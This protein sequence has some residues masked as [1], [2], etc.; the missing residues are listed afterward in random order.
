MKSKVYFTDR[1][2]RSD[3]N[4]LDKIELIFNKL[5]LKKAIK[6]DTKV[7]IKAHFG[8]WGNTN[9]IR[10]SYVRKIVDLVKDLGGNPY[11][12]ESCGLGYGAGGTYGGRTTSPEYLSMASLNGFT[13]GTVGAPIIIADG[14]WGN[15]V[16]RV[17][18]DGDYIKSVDVAAATLDADIIIVLTHAKGHGLSG[19]GGTI[20]NLGIGMVG[21]RSKAAMHTLGDVTVNQGKCLG[22]SCSLCLKVCPVR[23]ISMKD[24]AVIDQDACIDCLHCRGVCSRDAKAGAIT[25]TWRQPQDQAVRFVENALGVI[26]SLGRDRFYFINLAIDISDKCDCWNVGAPLLVHD[27]GIF[28]SRDPLAIDQATL[29]AI[30][31]SAPNLESEAKAVHKGDCIFA[32]AHNQRNPKTGELI[33]FAEIQFAHAQKKGLGSRDYDLIKVTKKLPKN[34]VH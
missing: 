9:Y 16:Y 11:V 31:D 22:P 4:M 24:K 23:C 14:Y 32:V 26:D 8:A 10:P 15:D 30:N 21:K 33:D 13:A 19:L 25:V 18:V 6:K 1:Q 3:F 17:D 34:Q 28:G 29:D 7:M 5:G 2:A 27:I 12:A 20:K